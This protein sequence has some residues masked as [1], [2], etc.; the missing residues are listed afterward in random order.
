VRAA[1]FAL[2]ANDPQVHGEWSVYWLAEV[3]ASEN[4]VNGVGSEK[5]RLADQGILDLPSRTQSSICTL[6]R[7]L[8]GNPFRLIT[9]NPSCLTPKVVAL[10]QSIYDN[11][12]FDRLPPW[13]T[14]WKKQAAITLKS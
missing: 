4:A 2:P 8:F 1:R 7:D 3:A 11:R 9:L 13:P 10:A 14:P 12:T 5:Q 6:L